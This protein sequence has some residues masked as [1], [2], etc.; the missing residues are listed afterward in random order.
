MVIPCTNW[1]TP[2]Q[3]LHMACT[4]RLALRSAWGCCVNERGRV[5]CV[6][7][8]VC[9]HQ[10]VQAKPWGCQTVRKEHVLLSKRVLHDS[11]GFFQSVVRVRV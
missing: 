4:E 2:E 6:E 5:G 10:G 9:R 3:L 1:G 8:G 11:L 7:G